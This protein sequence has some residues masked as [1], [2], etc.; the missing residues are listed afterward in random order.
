MKPITDFMIAYK[1]VWLRLLGY[2]VIPS[3]TL[4]LTQTET[5]SDAQW[6]G[7]GTFLKCRLFVQCFI[8]GFTALMAYIDTSL[9]RARETHKDAIASR[10]ATEHFNKPKP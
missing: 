3:A 2:V 1:L 9:Q 10:E 5:Y 7:M 6:A 4:F 8:A